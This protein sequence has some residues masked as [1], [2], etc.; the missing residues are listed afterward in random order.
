MATTS[1]PSPMPVE[2]T[3]CLVPDS[4]RQNVYRFNPRSHNNANEQYEFNS[5]K[6]SSLNRLDYLGDP[7]P[8]YNSNVE[9][10]PLDGANTPGCDINSGNCSYNTNLNI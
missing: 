7:Q 4:E 1:S 5:Y 8:T 9:S 3:S 6:Y 2:T 10:E